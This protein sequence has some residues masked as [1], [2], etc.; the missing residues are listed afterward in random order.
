M[1]RAKSTR[2]RTIKRNTGNTK[3]DQYDVSLVTWNDTAKF[4]LARLDAASVSG[5]RNVVVE[6][7]V[8]LDR[9]E[10]QGAVHGA[11]LEIYVAQLA[12]QAS[13]NRALSRA[14]RAVNCDDEFA[15]K[16]RGHSGR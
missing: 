11:A 13:G 1:P 10:R 15:S 9:F 4:N 12:G 3:A 16:R 2:I 7:D 5:I 14:G 6:G 8:P